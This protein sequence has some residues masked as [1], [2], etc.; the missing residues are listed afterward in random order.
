MDFLSVYLMN[1]SA[2]NAANDRRDAWNF[3][4]SILDR[5]D[6]EIKAKKEAD[7]LERKN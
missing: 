4:Q 3:Q 6:S 1:L 7:A 5:A 2:Q